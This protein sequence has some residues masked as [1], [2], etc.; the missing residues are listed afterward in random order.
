MQHLTSRFHRSIPV[1]AFV[2]A[3]IALALEVHRADAAIV[4][5]VGALSGEL[6]RYDSNDPVGTRT[7]ITTT[8]SSPTALVA[9]PDGNL[10]IGQAGNGGSMAPSIVRYEIAS[11]TFQTIHTFES[12]I[13]TPGS[14]AFQG[15]SLLVGRNPAIGA[16]GA[17]R[18]LT[19]ALGGAV[20]VADYTTG[21]N[22]ASSPG[23][24]VLSSGE[25]IVSDQF[26]NIL[27]G[28]RS[29]SVKRFD[30]AGQYVSTVVEDGTSGLFGPA[31]LATDG[32]WLFIASSMTGDILRTNLATGLTTTFAS[33]GEKYGASALALLADGSLLVGSEIFGHIRHFDANGTLLS[34]FAALDGPTAGFA[35]FDSVVPAPSALTLIALGFGACRR[36]R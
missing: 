22:L 32:T 16:A 10:Y 2:G 20:S 13:D 5:T 34:T 3:S 14:L 21:G 19:N 25:F 1:L 28:V 24:A 35:V 27:S 36:R 29:G 30:A 9:G 17:I 26:L 8:L 15:S 23:L 31:G 6:I 12:S 4:F 18:Q 7:V 11:N 33:T